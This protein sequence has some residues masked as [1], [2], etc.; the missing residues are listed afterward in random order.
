MFQRGGGFGAGKKHVATGKLFCLRAVTISPFGRGYNWPVCNL[1]FTCAC[2][3]EE[4]PILSASVL[5]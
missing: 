4:V 3:A 5:K 1:L 2:D